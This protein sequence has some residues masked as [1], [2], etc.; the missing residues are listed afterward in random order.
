MPRSTATIFSK[1]TPLTDPPAERQPI[2][3]DQHLD[4]ELGQLFI[5]LYLKQL[6]DKQAD[7]FRKLT[8][9]HLT[10]TQKERAFTINWDTQWDSEV[11]AQ[12]FH[13]LATELSSVP[14]QKPIVSISGKQ[15]T[16]QIIDTHNS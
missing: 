3:A 10:I 16:I 14:E 11:N 1:K 8:S 15:V 6:G 4:T 5:M 13:T 2:A 12:I 7:Q 9:D